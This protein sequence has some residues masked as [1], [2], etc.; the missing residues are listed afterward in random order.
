[1][2]SKA[3]KEKEL[4]EAAVCALCRKPFGHTQLPLFF[5]V[6]IERWGVRFDAI[7]RQTGLTLLLGNDARIAAA[8]GPDED[9]ANVLE[10]VELT[11]CEH[12]AIGEVNLH[13]LMSLPRE[14][15]DDRPA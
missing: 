7:R 5:R 11:I 14:S 12:C 15:T 3:M 2:V 13:V 10:S 6:K 4:R 8:M 9:M 1:M